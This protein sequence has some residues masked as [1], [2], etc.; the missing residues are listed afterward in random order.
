MLAFG[1]FRSNARQQYLRTAVNKETLEKQ[2]EKVILANNLEMYEQ[3]SG[4]EDL[5]LGNPFD[6]N[7]AT[8]SMQINLDISNEITQ[9]ISL[10]T[11]AN[12]ESDPLANL[13]ENIDLIKNIADVVSSVRAR[14]SQSKHMA[15]K[16]AILIHEK[17]IK[18]LNL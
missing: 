16:K 2:I 17:K 10:L 15:R 1:L 5:A 3:K 18:S 4:N 9:I 12:P 13:T 6:H 7:Q 11:N 8:M 14:I